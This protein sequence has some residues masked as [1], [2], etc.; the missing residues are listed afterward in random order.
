MS[1]LVACVFG[2]TW[3]M[4]ISGESAPRSGRILSQLRSERFLNSGAFSAAS[5]EATGSTARQLSKKLN[6]I[7]V[8]RYNFVFIDENKTGFTTPAEIPK[9]KLIRS[10]LLE[11]VS[12]KI[13]LACLA[14]LINVHVL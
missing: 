10:I 5:G 7:T 6:A 1:R 4:L 8:A 11:K 13:L 12:R 2:S 14:A 3:R 9:I